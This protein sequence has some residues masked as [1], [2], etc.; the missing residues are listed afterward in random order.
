MNWVLLWK[1][2]LLFTLFGYSILVIIVFFGG[3][4]NINEM[5]KDLST[6]P[7]APENNAK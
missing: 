2:V 7:Q 4:K 1:G 5:L 3:I 6:P